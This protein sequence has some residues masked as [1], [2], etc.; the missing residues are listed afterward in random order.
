MAFALRYTAE[1]KNKNGQTI[2]AN[3]LKDGYTGTLTRIDKIG[4]TVEIR[5]RPQAGECVVG[6]ELSFSFLTKDKTLFADLFTANYKDFKVE[7]LINGIKKWTG[8]LVIDNITTEYFNHTY[9]IDLSFNDS[10]AEL[11]RHTITDDAGGEI[12]GQRSLLWYIKNS[13]KFTDIPL[14]FT[15]VLN[16]KEANLMT[17]ANDNALSRSNLIA[18]RFIENQ[19]G[20]KVISS[21]KEVI[22]RILKPL[23]CIIF[24][25]ENKFYIINRSES[26]TKFYNH[27]F[28]NLALTSTGTFSA[29]VDITTKKFDKSNELVKIRPIKYINARYLN[30][31]IP[32]SLVG[33]SK[34]D[35]TDLSW[36]TI[37]GTGNTISITGGE[38]HYACSESPTGTA[39]DASGRTISTIPINVEKKT[40]N[41]TIRITFD[42]Y[43]KKID[44]NFDAVYDYT[45]N[46]Q[47]DLYRPDG[48]YER[49]TITRMGTTKAT[50]EAEFK[51][52]GT[53]Q[54]TLR[55]K[56]IAD[57]Q[58]K[59]Y[60]I[61]YRID[62]VDFIPV[63]DGQFGA[64]TTFDRLFTTTNT[65]NNAIDF[66]EV[67]LYVGDGKQ[68]S[69]IA[70]LTVDGTLTSKW[71]SHGKNEGINLQHLY[72]LNQLR[73][74]QKYRNQVRLKIID[75]TFALI[76]FQN[77]ILFD[78]KKYNFS[79]YTVSY[80]D[81]VNSYSFTL[82]E[83]VTT[84]I[85][86]LIGE[87][88][89]TSVN[90]KD[91]GTS[92]GGGSSSSGTGTG[93]TYTLPAATA[94]T[95]GGVKVPSGGSLILAGDGGL[96]LAPDTVLNSTSINPVQNK[97]VHSALAGK[98][99][100]NHTHTLEAVTT[101]GN[102]TTKGLILKSSDGLKQFTI[103]VDT[104]GHLNLNGGAD[105]NVISSGDFS[106]FG[107]SAPVSWWDS[108]P[109]ATTTSF[110]VVK[111]GTNLSIDANGFLN[112]ASGYV[113]PT[114]T[115]TVLGGVKVG[116]NLTITN[117]VLSADAQTITV[118]SA[119]STTSTNPVQNSVVTSALNGKSDNTHGHGVFTRSANG[120]VPFPTTT[121]STRYLREDGTWVVPTNTTYAVATDLELDTATSTTGRLISGERINSWAT[122][123]GFLTT[124]P[125]HTHDDLYY[126]SGNDVT[127]GVVAGSRISAGYD[128]GQG[129]SVNADNWFRSSGTTGWYNATYGGG[130]YMTDTTWVR[131]YGSKSL[132]CDQKI[133]SPVLQT[134][135]GDGNGFRLWESSMYSI[136]MA[137]GGNTTWGGRLD[138]TSDYNMYFRMGSGTNRG[139]VFLNDRTPV[140]Q[141]TAQGVFLLQNSAQNIRVDQA[142]DSVVYYRHIAHVLAGSGQISVNGV[143]GG[144]TWSQGKG[145]VRMNVSR[146]D[147]IY[148]QSQFEGNIGNSG[149]LEVYSD[150]SN[151]L[152]VYLVTGVYSQCN[153]NVSGHGSYVYGSP[154]PTATVP[155]GTKVHDTRTDAAMHLNGSNNLT[156]KAEVTAFS[157]RRIKKDIET[158]TDA[159]GIVSQLRGV[160]Y[161]RTDTEDNKTQ[162]G[163]IAQEVMEVLPEV[164]HYN[165]TSDRYSVN[166]SA[167]VAVL[168][169]AIKDQQSQIDELKNK[170]K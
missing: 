167:M 4:K 110:G 28:S 129:G 31:N 133:Q 38:L 5:Y 138:A 65:A 49:K 33:N 46:L 108:A 53:G 50:F 81:A 156:V 86:Y 55:L 131:T 66:Q 95:I 99:N 104:N 153:I 62:N 148:V 6:S 144:H 166:Y 19:S 18:E 15:I 35:T 34:F 165:E 122:R 74:N 94:A 21:A 13:V 146:R 37:S 75:N 41:D 102:T 27:N 7:F 136:Y 54:Y 113:L 64:S 168:I 77:Q 14:N 105:Q 143:V 111:I 3:I 161:K 112:A 97:V 2:T 16:T 56:D 103:T 36:W 149:W 128:S 101:A 57:F 130:V 139:F 155:T 117:G 127:F 135:A 162:V 58:S 125:A 163:V 60:N 132:Y 116:A 134:N 68:D 48:T 159:T 40:D 150:A 83:L 107:T 43:L 70:N 100:T 160:R 147:N 59:Y 170:L 90:G 39:P 164:V 169:E 10:L 87:T 145:T 52:V 80:G 32:V 151:N 42:Y 137:T 109:Q 69:D 9:Q 98:S 29:V 157:D 44:F 123:K 24:Q 8:W 23:E 126:R 114:A 51:N 72:A 124:I 12:S 79:D 76:P 141:I 142:A 88:P 30:K 121:T 106:A 20:K 11:D 96:T 118:D 1:Y 85:T 84:D 154:V 119:L 63:M 92:S 158:I 89:L 82:V 78:G 26:N 91:G 47:V 93:S 73:Q 17:L 152:N 120:F 140:A 25:A 115:A 45:P 67:D 71:Y 22:N 61:N